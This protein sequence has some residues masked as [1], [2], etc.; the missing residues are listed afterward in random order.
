MHYRYSNKKRLVILYGSTKLGKRASAIRLLTQVNISEILELD[1]TI[2]DLATFNYAVGKAY[3]INSLRPTETSG[4]RVTQHILRHLSDILKQQ[5]SYFIITAD[6]YYLDLSHLQD[7]YLL[8]WQ[9]LPD[10]QMTLARHLEWHM[11]DAQ[12][13]DK[14][15][16]TSEVQSTLTE[17]S[18]P[19]DIDRFAFLLAKVARN[20]LSLSDAIFLLGVHIQQAVE[21]WFH[22]HRDLRQRVFLITLSVLSGVKYQVVEEESERLIKMLCTMPNSTESSPVEST[23]DKTRTELLQDT[24]AQLQQGQ[25]NTEWGLS[26]IEI[27]SLKNPGYQP[28]VLAY[29][30]HEYANLRKTLL[31]WIYQLGIYHRTEVRQRLAVAVGTLSRHDFRTVLDDVVRNWAKSDD[32]NLWAL[33]ALSLS[34]AAQDNNLAPQVLKLLRHWS[35]LTDSPSLCW[36]AVLALGYVSWRFPDASMRDLHTIANSGSDALILGVGTAVTMVFSARG[37]CNRVAI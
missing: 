5:D 16:S 33:A 23:F 10:R 28:A 27:V 11:P 7:D 30:W 3:I 18:N 35:R 21:S 6:P 2:L 29:V 36:T 31:Q 14:L 8:T 37:G 32:S 25:E 17:I 4:L 34:V 12:L 15:L 13:A 1:P 19:S 20:E 26:P 24:W 22:D 9:D